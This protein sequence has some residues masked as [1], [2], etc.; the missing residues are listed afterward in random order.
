MKL[1]LIGLALLATAYGEYSSEYDVPQDSLAVLEEI[2]TLNPSSSQVVDDGYRYRTVKRFRAR[3]RRDVSELT[4]YLPPTQEIAYEA[5]SNEYL[6]PIAPIAPEA[7][8]ASGVLADDGYRYKTVRK[9]RHRQRRDVSELTQYLPPAQEIAYEA[10]SNEYLAPIAPIA[11]EAQ[12]ASGVLADDGYRYKTVRKLRHR[13]RRDVSELTQYLPPAQEIAYEAPSNEYLAPISEEVQISSGVL[14]DDGYRYK[15][16]RKLRHRQ[17]RDVSELTQYLPPA[18]EIA[19]EA[20]S[21][22]YL[23][24][25]SQE[26]QISSGVLADD[27]YRYKTVRKLRHRQRRDVSELTQYLPPSQE[28]A[29]E[30]PSNEY[31]APIAPIAS[32][33]LADDGYRYK[34]VRRSR[35]RRD[36]SELASAQYLPPV[37]EQIPQTPVVSIAPVADIPVIS[38]EYLA[39]LEQNENI[40]ADDGYRYKTVR[41]FKIRQRRRIEVIA[42]AYAALPSNEYL[43]PLEDAF[44]VSPLDLQTLSETSF[45]A[46]DG[47]R[48]KTQKRIRYRHRRD[49]NELPSNEYL[50]PVEAPITAEAP[51]EAAAPIQ[52]SAVLADDGYRYK[53]VRRIRYRHRRDVNE[54]PSNEY[55]PPVDAAPITAEAPIEAAAPIQD[56]AVLADDGYRYKTVRRIR[57][58]HRR[59]VNELP[60]NEYLPPVE[61]PITV[62]APIEAAAPIQDSAV[63]A[64]DGYRYKTVRRI[65]YRHRR[66]VNELPSN[67]YLPPVEAPITV[68]APIEAAAPIQDSAVL[69]DDGYRYKTVRRIRYRHRRDVNELPSNEYLPPVEAPIT[70]EAPI[71]A[72]API[73]DSAVLAD[74]GYRYKTVRRIR[75]RHRRDVNELPS[76]EYLPP[77]EAVEAPIEAVAPIQDSAVLADDGYRYKTVRRIRY[78]HRRD[79]NELPSN[80]YL[81]PVE[82]PI[83]AEAPIE[84]VA[85]I[86]DSAVLADDGY[87][88]KTVR[89][90]RYRHRRDVNELPSNEYLPP[91]EAPI[92][93]EAPI[94]AVA[95]IQDSAVLADDGYRYKTVRRIRYRHRRDVNELPSNEYLPPV[96]APITAE[97]PVAPVEESAVLADDGYRYKTVKRFRYRYRH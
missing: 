28:I 9:L 7:Q 41:R 65:R 31:L 61:A 68:E 56:S 73:Q 85:P 44:A 72:A 1:F 39:P 64:D 95:P 34:T 32:G 42:T 10:P 67:E 36:V 55:L 84:A 33:V 70:V 81:P 66:D 6:A 50:P 14:A 13:Q 80:E 53:T 57:Y 16:V 78:R 82:A 90:I 29:Y 40:L 2:E 63:L 69:A 38:N 94:E 19:Y 91:V 47:Y 74:D 88:Y 24:P 18:Q 97:A 20:P 58:R 4:Q 83:T 92:T 23:A 77:V 60:S 15:T 96:E 27:G 54:L 37:Q 51:I 49:V 35:H 30:A 46:D 45:L 25:I 76:N 8:I 62:E 75:Y 59:D 86:Q 17:R 89:R 71:E 5:P 22:E 12:I 43:P 52:D 11:P 21:N 93:A 3:H 87:R 26:V 48:Y 79:V